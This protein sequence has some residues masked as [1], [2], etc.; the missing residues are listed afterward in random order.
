MPAL[1]IRRSG[2]VVFLS[3]LLAACS[4]SSSENTDGAGGAPDDP[5]SLSGS[6]GD[7]P[8]VDAEIRVTDVQGELLEQHSSDAF[9]NYELNLPADAALPVLVTASGGTDLVTGRAVDFT[10]VGAALETG[11]RTVNLSPLSTVAVRGAQCAVD[12]LTAENLQQAWQRVRE[13]L[14]MGLDPAL[15]ADPMSEPVT[16]ANIES[17]VLANEAL[18]E[19][20]RRT[21]QALSNAGSPA[22]G[23]EVIEQIACDLVGRQATGSGAPVDPRLILTFKGQELAVRLEALA[24]RLEVDGSSAVSR[25]NESIRTVMPEFAD[26]AVA[27]VPVTASARDQA[28]ALA[29]LFQA[30]A[31][32]DALAQLTLALDGIAL[33]EVADL[34]NTALT[35]ALQGDINAFAGNLA[36]ADETTLT[37]LAERRVQR[38]TAS[39]PVISLAAEP[40]Q[41]SDGATTTLSWAS[42]NAD[43]C[44][45]SGGWDGSVALE[46]ATRTAPL[47]QTTDFALACV[48]LGGTARRDLTVTVQGAPEPEPEPEPQ[49]EPE[50]EPQPEP[51][52]EPEPEPQPE[53]TPAPTLTLSV[54]DGVVLRGGNATLSWSAS[55]AESCSAGGGWSGSRATSGSATVGPIEA[56]TTYT[57]SCSGDGGSVTDSVSVEV[58]DPPPEPTVD[59]QA[60]ASVI[61]SGDSAQL[62]W[63][64]SDADTCSASGGW[65]GSRPVSGSESV[66]PLMEQ[67]TFSLN[68][69]GDG[70][71]AMAMISV[72]I[73]GQ[74]DLE[75]Q[76]PT[77]NTDGS[78][79][80]DLD[81]YRIHYGL[82]SRSYTDVLDVAAGGTSHSLSLPSGSY[83]FAMT[84]IDADGNESAYS[85]EVVKT[86]N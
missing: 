74:V 55:D 83:Y 85:N 79:L 42:S 76:A 36:L 50:P 31:G 71:N 73:N 10:L 9:A 81:G 40:S 26:P 32:E 8:V 51:E 2:F 5:I 70:G 22:D 60:A 25:M 43:W 77:E 59:L 1:R 20:V 48:G 30:A 58:E 13:E 15:V 56:A 62:S 47:S 41:I 80:T 86:V 12:G 27:Q 16:R 29:S 72:S 39:R 49:P 53:P 57:L 61:D 19:V 7:G 66:G 69:S 14:S 65:S 35:P 6:V 34:V 64:S 33:G 11:A 38:D 44:M 82:T 75:W 18:G 3:F 21:V 68:C 4:G 45:A 52:P 28:V 63:N 67:T 23:D 54:S 24:G 17:V 78:E 46:G 84:A 37:D